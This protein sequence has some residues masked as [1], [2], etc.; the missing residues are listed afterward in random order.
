M[1]IKSGHDTILNTVEECTN[2]VKGEKV[3]DLL[4]PWV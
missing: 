1:G 2:S 4:C 3:L